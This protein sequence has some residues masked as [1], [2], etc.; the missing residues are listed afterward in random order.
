MDA[1]ENK[2]IYK[3]IIKDVLCIAP[4]FGKKIARNIFKKDLKCGNIFMHLEE[5]PKEENKITLDKKIKDE[6]GIP[7]TNLFYKKSNTTLKTAKTILEEFADIC[8]K[9]EIGRVA[10]KKDIDQLKNYESLGVFH[11][12]GG[13]RIGKTINNSVVDTNLKVHNNKNL[14]IAGSSVFPSSGYT[15]PT[16]TIVQLSLRLG[17]YIFKEIS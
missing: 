16:F 15:N 2:K 4:K 1:E 7:I 14:F 10:V 12:L 9:L 6:N 13:T 8:R 5:E 3:E 11:H 17:E